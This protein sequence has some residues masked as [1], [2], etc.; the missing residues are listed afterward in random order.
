MS[1]VQAKTI[2]TIS[3]TKNGNKSPMLTSPS[4][5]QQSV[6]IKIVTLLR[7]GALTNSITSVREFNFMT[8]LQIVGHL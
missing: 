8:L 6:L 7:S 2:H 1:L 3:K 4:E 5:S